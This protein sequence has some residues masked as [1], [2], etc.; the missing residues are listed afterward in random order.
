MSKPDRLVVCAS[1]SPGK[2]RDVDEVYGSEFRGA[3]T[4]ARSLVLDFDPDYIVLFGGDHR[5]AFRTIV[6]TF[7][8]AQSAGIMAEAG[9]PAAEL[10]VPR[11]KARALAEHLLASDIDITMCRDIE[12]D[13]A[14]AQPLR[15]LLSAFE[16]DVSYT[17]VGHRYRDRDALMD[18]CRRSAN[19]VGRLM[20]Y[21]YGVRDAQSLEQSDAICSALQLINFWQD[22]GEDLRRGR[23]YLPQG[24]TMAEEL[25]FARELMM[26]GMPLAM[27]IPLRDGTRVGMVHAELPADRDWKAV[28]SLSFDQVLSDDSPFRSIE[29][30]LIWSR[31][32]ARTVHAIRRDRELGALLG[33]RSEPEEM[34]DPARGIDVLISGHTITDNKQPVVELNRW[35][36]DTGSYQL[37]GKVT[38]VIM[39]WR[40]RN[41]KFA[42]G[43]REIFIRNVNGDPLFPFCP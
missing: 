34:L 18:Y 37:D 33:R 16:Q 36:I 24:H 42:F 10:N 3:L 20:L 35:F 40:I 17:S 5:R 11:A 21:L 4:R 14:F 27:E 8:V 26:Q 30:E 32:I 15:D 19:P 22:R 1:H 7:G 6:P 25:R 43:G 28:E 2:D 31:R 38:L 9:H 41:N 29:T 12:L 13:H 39:P 23:D